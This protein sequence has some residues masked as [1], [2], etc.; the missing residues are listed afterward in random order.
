MIATI[1]LTAAATA[2]HTEMFPPEIKK[3]GVVMPA[4]VLDRKYFDAS[5]HELEKV[6]C[7]VKLA[8]RLSFDKR[9][10]LEDRVADFEEMW[11]DPE[12]D[13]I[14]CARGGVG[15]EEVVDRLDWT[16]LS[17][18]PNQRLVG[19]SNVT[20]LLNAML[21]RRVGKP[22][23]GPNFGSVG[24]C[25][26]DT[27]TWL[28]RVLSG[29]SLPSEQLRPIRPGAF[30]GKSC[31]GHIGL[32]RK[33][34]DS[35]WAS[36]PSNRVVFLERNNSATVA[37]IEKELDAI[38]ASGYLSHASGVVFGDVTPGM[39]DSGERWGDAKDFE[40]P[41]DLALAKSALEKVKADFAYK[42]R[43]PVYDGFAHGHIPVMH[44]IDFERV[45]VVSVDGVMKWED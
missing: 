24:A 35:G 21:K 12:V 6:G 13:L 7:Q 19:F 30:S 23:S 18:R 8:K 1:L 37:G 28:C 22:Y 17:S 9:A 4:S 44:T 31:G 38:L 11:M 3:V 10:S 40:N 43:C 34:I 25:S 36:D 16:K 42:V 14:M 41:A 5:I 32:L 45:V 26:G 27:M 20:V 33:C 2:A 15:C 39:K 29:K